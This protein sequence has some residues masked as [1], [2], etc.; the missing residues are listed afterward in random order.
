[1]DVQF[2]EVNSLL[3]K[4]PK[5]NYNAVERNLRKNKLQEL[6]GLEQKSGCKRLIL[7]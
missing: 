4:L 2:V 6:N 1:M 3:Q 7:Y 5:Q